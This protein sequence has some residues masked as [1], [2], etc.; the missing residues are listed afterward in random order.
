[1]KRALMRG[2]LAALL[3]VAV[4]T[5]V[6]SGEEIAKSYEFDIDQW[7]EIEATDGPVTLHRIRIDRKEARLNKSVLA[8]PYN[9]QY[10]EPIRFQ[11]EYSNG[12]S[13]KWRARITVRWL[14]E[15]GKIIDAFSANEVM[16]KKS[17]QKS[18]TGISFYPQVW[19]G[20]GKDPR[21]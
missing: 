1:M 15:D 19:P 14:D 11:L 13:E 5:G 18:G 2:M 17:A 12:S 9:Q 16:G 8:R 6:A 21:G 4:G 7:F 10:L 3:L 20:A